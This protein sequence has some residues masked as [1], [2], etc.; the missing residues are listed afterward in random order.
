MVFGQGSI[1]T[2]LDRFKLHEAVVITVTYTQCAGFICMN[3]DFL[4][5]D[6]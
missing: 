5:K 6:K 3:Y 4:T 2:T 1:E